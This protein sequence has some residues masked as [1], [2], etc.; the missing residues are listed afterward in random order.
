MLDEVVDDGRAG[1][2]AHDDPASERTLV[3][4]DPV[5]LDDGR[6]AAHADSAAV[7]ALV[8][9][10]VVPDDPGRRAVRAMDP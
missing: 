9:V 6:R 5:A 2:V 8:V 10:D 4:V 3:V 1:S 7:A